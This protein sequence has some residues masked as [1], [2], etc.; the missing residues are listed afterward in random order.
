MVAQLAVS[1]SGIGPAVLARCVDL[2][3]ELDLRGVP[4]SL[5]LAPRKAV[6]GAALD[7]VRDR[8]SGRDVLVMHGFD[9]SADPYS[10]RRRAE[11]SA[12]PA[13]EAGLRL[14]AARAALHRLG[15]WTEAFAP[16][17]W[18]ASPGTLVALRRHRFAVCADMSGVRDLRTGV[19]VAGRVRPVAEHW[20]YL[21]G[22]GRAAR[23]DGLVRLGV[24]AAGL[25]RLATRE[26]LL[27]AVDLALHHGASPVTYSATDSPSG[28]TLN[29][30]PSGA[31][32]DRN[33]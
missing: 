20:S 5:L 28:S 19:V 17:G 32:A 11:F 31:V 14:V 26:V 29:S 1:L 30:A 16:P 27:E 18:L 10:L 22:V 23:R 15:L 33:P 13:H 7:W 6:E 9:H 2:A 8:L 21:L 3:R 12:L 4:L 25:D 24:D